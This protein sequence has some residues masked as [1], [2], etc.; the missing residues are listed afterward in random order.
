[1]LK[2]EAKMFFIMTFFLAIN[3]IFVLFLVKLFDSLRW[4]LLFAIINTKNTK[5]FINGTKGVRQWFKNTIKLY[6]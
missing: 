2:F 4:V 1:M 3:V 5:D 6:I